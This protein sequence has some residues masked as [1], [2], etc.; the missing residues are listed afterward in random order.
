ML[1]RDHKEVLSEKLRTALMV[2]ILPQ[3]LQERVAEHLDRLTTYNEVH[4]KIIGLVQASSRYSASM[5]WTAVPST[6]AT[7]KVKTPTSMHCPET[8]VQYAMDTGTTPKIAQRRREKQSARGSKRQ[9][10]GMSRTHHQGKVE[11]FA[12]TANVR[13]IRRTSAGACTQR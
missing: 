6:I 8:I 10:P 13:A 4:S 9:L 3:T 5:P 2:S 11:R 12:P 7:K 1:A